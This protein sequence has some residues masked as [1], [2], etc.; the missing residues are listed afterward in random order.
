MP[1]E[2]HA[3]CVFVCVCVGC[4]LTVKR[5]RWLCPTWEWYL[6]PHCW[7]H[8]KRQW[9]PWWT[10]SFRTLWWRS[11]LK[12]AT[13]Y[14]HRTDTTNTIDIISIQY[15]YLTDMYVYCKTCVPIR[16]SVRPQTCL[17]HYPRLHPLGQLLGGTKP[18]VCQQERGSLDSTLLL[19]AWQTTTVSLWLES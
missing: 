6:A 3:N 14:T 18:S 4:P 16:S 9:L 2:I 5:T 12:T 10:S 19:C 11:L 1:Y 8:R 13:R 17:Y 7:G 15:T